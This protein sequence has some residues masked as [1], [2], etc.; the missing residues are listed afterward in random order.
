[1]PEFNADVA[2]YDP[3]RNF[4]FVVT[5]AGRRVAGFSKVSLLRRAIDAATIPT[6]DAPSPPHP[7]PGE[8]VF[9]P[10]TLERGVTRDPDFETW[11]NQVWDH[12]NSSGEAASLQDFRKDIVIE[13]YN[14]AG[15][16]VYA[17]HVRNCWPSEMVALP[18]LDGLG[19]TIAIQTLVLQNEGWERIDPPVAEAPS[20][21]RT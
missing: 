7:T 16:A 21:P 6:R 19:N 17:Y 10:I 1:M 15:Q 9:E 18:E 2:R 11:A 8:T 5:W 4:K 14:E 12:A 3:Y 13:L 20:S